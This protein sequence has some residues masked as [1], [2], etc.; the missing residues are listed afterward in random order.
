MLAITTFTPSPVSPS[1]P[2]SLS[3]SLSSVHFLLSSM[4]RPAKITSY[5][6]MKS[7]RRE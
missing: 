3:P 7:L 5:H 2:L 4:G 6:M 1:L